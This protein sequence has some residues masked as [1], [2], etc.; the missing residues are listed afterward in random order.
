[1][2]GI[3]LIYKNGKNDYFDP[4]DEII[5]DN[6]SHQYKIKADTIKHIETY[7]ED[8]EEENGMLGKI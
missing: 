3:K 4:C 1:M 8:E 5:I 2:A 6:G 7:E